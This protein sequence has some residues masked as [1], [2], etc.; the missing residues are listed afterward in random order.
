M[1][2]AA[3]AGEPEAVPRPIDLIAAVD[4]SLGRIEFDTI[5]EGRE[6]EILLRAVRQAII[7]V[8]GRRLGGF[9]LS[10][11]LARFGEGF[12]VETSDVTPAAEVLEQ[13]GPVPG[14]AKLLE[15]LGIEEESPG[16][17]ASALEF[18]MEGLHLTRR[19]NKDQG[20]RLGS[21]RYAGTEG[22]G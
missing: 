20:G 12:S 18:A 10:S 19:L 17:A 13:V 6:E 9:D 2:R 3:R 11:L 15:R 4:S 8:F 22:R 21:V 5:E 7:A 14:L 1:R 16:A